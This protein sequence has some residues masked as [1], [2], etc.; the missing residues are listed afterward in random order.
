MTNLQ[1]EQVLTISEIDYE[2][3]TEGLKDTYSHE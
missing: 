2:I 3:E 1:Q